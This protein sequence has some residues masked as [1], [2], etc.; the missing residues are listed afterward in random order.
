MTNTWNTPEW[1]EKRDA[2]LQKKI[3]EGKGFCEWCD[4]TENL[5]PA[6]KRKRGGYTNEE[7][8]DLEKN[9]Y[10]LCSKCNF[11]EGKKFKLCPVCKKGYYKPKRKRD[12]MCWNCL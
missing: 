8:M 11:M 10:V 7:Y 4:T 1:K 5:V 3:D 6:H 2:F 9:C 12:P